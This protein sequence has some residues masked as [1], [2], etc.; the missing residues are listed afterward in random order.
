M[1]THSDHSWRSLFFVGAAVASQ[2]SDRGRFTARKLPVAVSMKIGTL[3]FISI[4]NRCANGPWFN[5][6]AYSLRTHTKSLQCGRQFSRQL[7]AACIKHAHWYANEPIKLN[8]FFFGSLKGPLQKRKKSL[9]L[10]PDVSIRPRVREK[11]L[12]QEGA[13]PATYQLTIITRRTTTTTSVRGL[14]RRALR[15]APSPP[16]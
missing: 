16:H 2:R 13:W 6:S 5:Q 12:P 1:E 15:A 11:N 3:V 4:G 10:I 8:F 7:S 14:R 9:V